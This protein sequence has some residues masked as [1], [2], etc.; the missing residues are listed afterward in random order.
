[1]SWRQGG[2]G[3]LATLFTYEI[4]M[5]LRDRRTI[6][7]VV[8]APFLLFPALMLTARTVERSEQRRIDQ[9]RYTFAVG[10]SLASDADAWVDG[11]VALA[12]ESEDT[13]LARTRFERR[14]LPTDVEAAVASDS[15]DVVV[16]ALRPDEYRS[17][18][19]AERASADSAIESASRSAARA[20]G[21]IGGAGADSTGASDDPDDALEILVLRLLYRADRAVSRTAEGRMQSALDE[22]RQ[23]REQQLFQERGLAVDR[24]D[25]LPLDAQSIASAEKEGGAV[26]GVALTPLLLLLMLSGG[27]VVAADTIAG[28]KERGTLETILTTGARR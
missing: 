8:V 24:K 27:S 26:V 21:S 5:L 1:M 4:R 23:Q 20:A 9:T 11:A 7:I 22:L 13:V 3:V 2:S 6:F 18:R 17:V 28:E 14:P 19:A 25:V 15:L 12:R 16:L 10:G